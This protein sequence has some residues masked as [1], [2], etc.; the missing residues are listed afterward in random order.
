[1]LVTEDYSEAKG[2][3]VNRN[4]RTSFN[5]FNYLNYQKKSS[6]QIHSLRKSEV[7]FLDKEKKLRFVKQLTFLAINNAP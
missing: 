4:L 7:I 2:K 5:P 6:N 1:M 3:I